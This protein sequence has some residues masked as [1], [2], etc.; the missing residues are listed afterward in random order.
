MDE[1]QIQVQGKIFKNA[2]IAT[3]VYLLGAAFIQDFHIFD[4]DR[5]IGFSAFMI[6]SINM[7]IT[8]ISCMMLWKD[9]YFGISRLPQMRMVLIIFTLLALCQDI[10]FIFDIIRGDLFSSP[11]V[12]FT[13]LFMI[14]SISLLLWYI[15][16]EYQKAGND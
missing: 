1:R 13:S 5:N 9:A 4:I 2:F 10:L 7:L 12:G 14:N 6:L 8:Y 16:H 11:F 3:I 15:R